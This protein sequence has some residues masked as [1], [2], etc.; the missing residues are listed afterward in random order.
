MTHLLDASGLSCPLPVLR[1]RKRLREIAGGEVLEVIA[2]DPAAVQDFQ[3][4]CEATG[5]VLVTWQE[6]DG[7]FS[8]RIRKAA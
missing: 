5:H 1:A 7:V 8:F 2:T 4:F 6:T 3:S